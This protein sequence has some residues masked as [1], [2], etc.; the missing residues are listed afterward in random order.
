VLDHEDGPMLIHGLQGFTALAYS[1]RA[2]QRRSLT[3]SCSKTDMTGSGNSP[4]EGH[5]NAG[6]FEGRRSPSFCCE[7]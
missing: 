5:D 2:G 4:A 1:F 6:R 3:D 7:L